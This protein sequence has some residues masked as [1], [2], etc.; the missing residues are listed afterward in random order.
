[1]CV[2]G[3]EAFPAGSIKKGN[4]MFI[5][6]RQLVLTKAV[7][8]G[9]TLSAGNYFFHSGL[10]TLGLLLQAVISSFSFLFFYL[11]NSDFFF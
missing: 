4:Y 5:A 6:A 3:L 11:V 10:Y 9:L 2:V 1:M 8:K 7:Q